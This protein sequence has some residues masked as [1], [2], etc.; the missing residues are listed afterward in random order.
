MIESVTVL[1]ST[2]ERHGHKCDEYIYDLSFIM[3]KESGQI[4]AVFNNYK[5][6]YVKKRKET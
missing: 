2:G 4:V 1:N 6:F 5:E 3:L